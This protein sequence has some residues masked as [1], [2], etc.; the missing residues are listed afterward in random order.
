MVNFLRSCKNNYFI[1][2]TE[3][4]L[5][6]KQSFYTLRYGNNTNFDQDAQYNFILEKLN[7]NDILKNDSNIKFELKTLMCRIGLRKSLH[8]YCQANF[9]YE[10]LKN[11]IENISVLSVFLKILYN[12]KLL[13][14]REIRYFQEFIKQC[15]LPDK[16]LKESTDFLTSLSPI[17]DQVYS[18]LVK[19]FSSGQIS[20]ENETFESN[21]KDSINDKLSPQKMMKLSGFFR[22]QKTSFQLKK[23]SS[24]THENEFNKRLDASSS[25][26]AQKKRISIKKKKSK[27]LLISQKTISKELSFNLGKS[28]LFIS[29][30]SLESERT[31]FETNDNERFKRSFMG[32][33][34]KVLSMRQNSL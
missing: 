3:V 8:F 34:K 17:N 28:E 23:D 5:P 33:M 6:E 24:P 27:A 1:E 15:S 21:M 4:L 26:S 16:F 22:K 7:L 30:Y 32:N 31:P 29:S 9:E 10:G 25:S 13:E 2:I 20:I 11:L 14:T 12:E 18:C 19:T